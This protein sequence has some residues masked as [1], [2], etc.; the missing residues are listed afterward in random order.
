MFRKLESL[1]EVGGLPVC[2]LRRG[3]LACP[4]LCVT[5]GEEDI[6]AADVV[7]DELEGR[8]VQAYRL[9]VGKQPRGPIPGAS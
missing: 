3:H 9:F 4:R 6:A 7:L 8:L 1:G 2:L 5:Q